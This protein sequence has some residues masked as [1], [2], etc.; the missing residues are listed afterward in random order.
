M[1]LIDTHCHLDVEDFEPD[2]EAV[3][4]RARAAGV[5]AIV[6]P[7]IHA[8][9][10][11]GL[12]ALCASVPGRHPALGLHP[13]Y[14]EQHRSED[15]AALEQALALLKQMRI[16]RGITHAFSGSLQQAHH[17]I[18]LGFKLG[19]GGMLTFERS[20]KL[21]ALV[22]DL[23]LDAIVLE[24]VAP[25]LTVAAH[26][27]E[28]NSPEYLPQVLATLAEVRQEDPAAVVHR[29]LGRAESWGRR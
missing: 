3:I 23:P 6:V 2:R 8:A 22:R 11:Q 16:R 29:L 12:L 26:R 28:R 20:R 10:W 15:V 25:D 21:R 13:I 24:T 7:A 1:D 27:G 14:L 19:F 5:A 17:Y 18:D 9:G 4:A